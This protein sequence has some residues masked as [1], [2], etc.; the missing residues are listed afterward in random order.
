MTRS[1]PVTLVPGLQARSDAATVSMAK[2]AARS[3]GGMAVAW[4]DVVP[5][6]GCGHGV[7]H[8]PKIGYPTRPRL[9]HRIG[10]S[11]FRMV[12]IGIRAR[13]LATV[14]ATFGLLP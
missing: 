2:D 1:R 12:A 14:P 3:S 13:L 7:P 4:L 10:R 6:V 11:T 5:S 9:L 8:V